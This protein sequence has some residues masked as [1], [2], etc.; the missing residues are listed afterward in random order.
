MRRVTSAFVMMLIACVSATTIKRYYADAT[1][2]E[3]G[4]PPEEVKIS[5][6]TTGI[7]GRPDP[8]VAECRGHRFIC[9]VTGHDISCKEELQRAVPPSTTSAPE[10]KPR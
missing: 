1:A 7:L 3:I 4:C 10:P 9:S 6:E 2:G 8:W 5:G